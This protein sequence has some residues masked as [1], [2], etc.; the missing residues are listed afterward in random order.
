MIPKGSH[1][2]TEGGILILVG[3]IDEAAEK[4]R[5]TYIGTF[6]EDGGGGRVG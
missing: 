6:L 3:K 2:V 4:F 5:G 1:S